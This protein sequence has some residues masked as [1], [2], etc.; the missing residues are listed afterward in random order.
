MTKHLH[1]TLAAGVA[2][3]GL[4]AAA[5]AVGAETPLP[6]PSDAAFDVPAGKI[7]HTV[8][9]EKV[10][11]P[12]A[13]ASHT[14][15]V[16]WLTRNRSH[17]IVVDMATGRVR[18]ETVATPTR[19]RT[20]NA[21]DRSL[22]VE[23]RRRG[24]GLPV[25]SFTF[26]AA[27]QRAYLERGWTR[28]I[29]EKDVGGRR[30]LITENIAGSGWRS[31]PS[32]TR[33]V[34]VVDAETFTLYERTSTHPRGE[35][36]HSEE[37]P[38]VRV[39]DAT[40]ENL[41][42]TMAMKARARQAPSADAK[43]VPAGM[44]EHTVV[45]R[46]VAGTRAVP[47]RERTERWLTRA[48]SR[49]VVT[50]LATGKVRTEIVTGPYRTRI[51]DRATNRLTVTS[52]K[53]QAP[54]YAS[55]A[56]EAGVQRAYLEQ[57]V[58]RVIGDQQVAGRRALVVESVPGR[59]RSDEPQSRTVAT[60]DAETFALYERTTGQPDGAFSQTEVH[61]TAELLPASAQAARAR[62][63]MAP[64]PGAELVRR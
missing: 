53:R 63:A 13:I 37:Y 10:S 40:P 52:H 9:I 23:R 5:P 41:R 28:V 11:G 58:T 24:G 34:A 51:Y 17:T 64:H 44:V 47:S 54:P 20:Y 61:E 12:K 1:T 16:Q 42:A 62:L 6:L 3:L 29:G 21:A 45:V 36:V 14:K 7:E 26:E 60:I 33:T 30:A 59:W 32:E 49:T 57:G 25:T 38:V 31:D 55:A 56:Y 43:L 22:K 50:D 27:V 4:A 48:G 19:I 8:K 15:T 39:L 18:A 46:T 35:F 2:A